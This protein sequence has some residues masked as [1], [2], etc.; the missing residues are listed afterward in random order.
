[1]IEV[2]WPPEI[3]P[4]REPNH[5][6]PRPM[7]AVPVLLPPAVDEVTERLLERRIVVVRGTLDLP[8]ATEVGATLMLLDGSGDDPIDVLLS[9][10]DGDLVAASALA[11][12]VELVGVE[13]R[14]LAS[15]SVGGPAVLPYAVA[16]RRLAQPH[17]S[18]RL[19][20]PHVDLQGRADDVAA[21]SARHAELLDE[22]H[23]RLAGA[24]GRAVG[25]VADDLRR[26]RVLDVDGAIAYG[27]VDEVAR[28]RALRAV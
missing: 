26:G 21:E 19:R 3:P 20:D 4:W 5:E 6:P 17:A 25:Q 14:A 28:R 2:S 10:A 11:D 22:L 27:L 23:R 12:T 13:V 18:F 24:T 8:N 7:P 9:C 15:G 16:T 1:M